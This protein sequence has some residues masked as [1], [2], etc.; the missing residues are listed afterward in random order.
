MLA[1]GDSVRRP[2]AR[3]AGTRG[4]AVVA[5]AGAAAGGIPA[6]SPSPCPETS[7]TC[8]PYAAS[9]HLMAAP[10]KCI[11]YLENKFILRLIY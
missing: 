8:L 6:S 9:P 2:R 3:G 5:Y 4:R 1:T 10:M 7:F 11:L